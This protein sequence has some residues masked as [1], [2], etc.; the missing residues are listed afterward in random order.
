VLPRGQ[1][2]RYIN[3][4]VYCESC[5]SDH[6][7]DIL[8]YSDKPTP[9]FFGG[10]RAGYGVEL[11][12]DDGNDSKTRPEIYEPQARITSTSKTMDPCLMREWR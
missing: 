2:G 10:D 5:A 6:E 7:A 1:N 8:P 3:D 11:E 12:I 4:C 9:V